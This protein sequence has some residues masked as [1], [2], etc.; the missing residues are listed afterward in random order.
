MLSPL[1]SRTPRRR[2][3]AGGNDVVVGG[4]LLRPRFLT[5]PGA[6]SL[7]GT[8]TVK[9][10]SRRCVVRCYCYFCSFWTAFPSFGSPKTL[11]DV[12]MSDASFMGC[13]CAPPRR[14]LETL[15]I[16][17][18]TVSNPGRGLEI[19]VVHQSNVIWGPL[20][21]AQRINRSNRTTLYVRAILLRAERQLGQET[22]KK[23]TQG[24]CRGS[25]FVLP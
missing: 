21:F 11:Q 20:F 2:P 7:A 6:P 1:T 25:W 17:G 12:G 15:G 19:R 24:R 10:S 9:A 22:C 18:V 4:F 16:L 13:C 8:D 23:E 5:T 3:A 14:K